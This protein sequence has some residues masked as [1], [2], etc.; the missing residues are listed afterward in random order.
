MIRR[1]LA[2]AVRK[3]KR[4]PN[5]K[6]AIS[7]RQQQLSIKLPSF[8]ISILASINLPS[9]QQSGE[10]IY[11]SREKIRKK[12]FSSTI[13]HVYAHALRRRDFPH[14]SASSSLVAKVIYHFWASGREIPSMLFKPDRFWRTSRE[15]CAVYSSEV[16]LYMMVVRNW[17]P[18][19]L[20]FLSPVGTLLRYLSFVP[21][22]AAGSEHTVL[23]T[24]GSKVI[25][26]S[27]IRHDKDA[28]IVFV[29]SSPVKNTLGQEHG[30]RWWLWKRVDD[31]RGTLEP[32]VVWV[33][34]G[35]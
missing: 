22:R 13:A 15:S 5:E 24:A 32:F 14:P 21:G 26:N 10:K 25:K 27:V 6:K 16:G 1:G 8:I 9:N 20:L 33:V 35:V 12:H 3:A 19:V 2:T 17:R 34:V 30:Q 29:R 18:S 31:T 7:S 23:N 4:Y 28:G 11:P